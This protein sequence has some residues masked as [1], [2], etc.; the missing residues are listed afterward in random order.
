VD[1][2]EEEFMDRFGPLPESVRNLLFQLKVKILAE[3]AGLSSIGGESGQIVLRFP[4]GAVPPDLP[5]LGPSV[6]VGK[7]AL[8][9][10]FTTMPDWPQ[11]LLEVLQ[12]LASTPRTAPSVEWAA[13]NEG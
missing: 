11:R 4:E 6:R 13:I 12:K 1:A 3:A 2:L 9:M 7:V 5:D 10:P 8:W